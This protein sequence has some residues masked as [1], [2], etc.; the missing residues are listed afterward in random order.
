MGRLAESAEEEETEVRSCYI[1]YL[2]LYG[3]LARNQ[4]GR[5]VLALYEL[6]DRL[7]KITDL[8]T[9]CQNF[10]IL[11]TCMGGYRAT[12][13]NPQTFLQLAGNPNDARDYLLDFAFFENVC[14]TGKEVFLQNQVCLSQA[15]AQA[16]LS[17]RLVQ[18]GGTSQEQNQMMVCDRGIA[19]VGCVRDQIIQQC[20]FPSGKVVCSAAVNMARGLGQ[21][22]VTCIQQMDYVCNLE[23]RALPVFFAVLLF[24]FFVYF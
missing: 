20:G 2:A 6:Y 21:A 24:A 4:N 19:A 17:H 22:D 9:I 12:C 5:Q 16:S 7:I 8:K 13:S 3:L 10:D 1:N 11:T 23:H 15:F 14:G 18:C